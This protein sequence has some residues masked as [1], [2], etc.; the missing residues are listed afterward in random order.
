MRAGDLAERR[1]H[2]HEPRGDAT[3]DARRS[4]AAADDRGRVRPVEDGGDEAG[5]DGAGVDGRRRVASGGRA[6]AAVRVSARG[7]AGPR[8]AGPRVAGPRVAG[9]RVAEPPVDG[10]GGHGARDQGEPPLAVAPAS[11]SARPARYARTR[12][13]VAR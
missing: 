7:V 12:S 9:P 13:R 1:W 3:D 6:A 10:V 8:V 2:G 4:G 5:V 11:A